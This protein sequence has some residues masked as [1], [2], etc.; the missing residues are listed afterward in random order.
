MRSHPRERRAT[1]RV[2]R[3]PP[4]LRRLPPAR[5]QHFRGECG[6]RRENPEV[7]E[8][9]PRAGRAR[10]LPSQGTW[11]PTG[12]MRTPAALMGT[13][14]GAI[15]T[16]AALMGTPATSMR[17]LASSPAYPG[18]SMRMPAKLIGTPTPRHRTPRCQAARHGPNAIA[19]RR[20]A[21]ALVHYAERTTVDRGVAPREPNG[22]APVGGPAAVEVSAASGIRKPSPQRFA[23][24]HPCAQQRKRFVSP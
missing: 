20:K 13:P 15:R 17:A 1:A 10:W 24:D 2:T 23:W 14:T 18:S 9:N 12:A 7:G 5:R 19:A 8:P 4:P 6:R 22:V 21:V 16:P 11:S 3:R